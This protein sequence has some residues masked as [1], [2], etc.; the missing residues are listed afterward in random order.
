MQKLPGLYYRIWQ[1]EGE[2]K[3]LNKK[4]QR[5]Q[6]RKLKT[7]FKYIDKFT[8]FT[9]TNQSYEHFHVSS[10]TFIDSSRTSGKIKTKFCRKWIDDDEIFECDLWFYGDLPLE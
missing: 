10:D 5:G 2:E 4:K 3:M 6:H 7:M 1:K 8:P 9:E